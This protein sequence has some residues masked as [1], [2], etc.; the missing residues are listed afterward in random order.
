MTCIVAVKDGGRVVLAADSQGTAGYI[1]RDTRT[2]KAFRCGPFAFGVAGSL[3]VQQAIRYGFALALPD[4]VSD[5]AHFAAR[6]VVPAVRACLAEVGLMT[7]RDEAPHMGPNDDNTH[8]LVA[9]GGSAFLIESNL[10]LLDPDDDAICT[11][12]GAEV[13]YGALWALRCT[14][15]G[16][17]ARAR[18]AVGAAIRYSSGC[19]G[20][21]VVVWTD[22]DGGHDAGEEVREHSAAGDVSRPAQ[23]G[24]EQVG[25]GADR[26][27]P[28][29]GDD[30]PAR[31]PEEEAVSR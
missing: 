2:T 6:E 27:R 16:A 7:T 5:P 28:G 9:F 12:A 20:E 1:K 19:G 10:G 11:G 15:M 21:T 24:P 13:A 30:Q 8:V 31:R 29:G 3:A 22:A 26:Q 17:E 23:E 18:L 14:K 4:G 25:G